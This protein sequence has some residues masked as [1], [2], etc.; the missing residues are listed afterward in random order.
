MPPLTPDLAS[1]AYLFI[2]A[3]LLG[4]LTVLLPHPESFN[5]QWML[6]VLIGSVAVGALLLAFGERVPEWLRRAAPYGAAA[7]TAIVLL[8][9]GRATSAYLFFYLWVALYAFCFLSWREAI[10]LALF[11]IASYAGVIAGFRI[12]HFEANAV[13]AN[14]DVPAMVLLAGTVFVAGAFVVLLRERVRSLISQLAT[15][16]GSDP[17]T[18]LL[19]RR[20]F[21]HAAQSE[22][23]RAERS[24]QRFSLLHTDCDFFKHLNDRLGHTAGDE[25]LVAIGWMLEADRR[26]Y[27]VVARIGGEEFAVLLPQTD[28]QE[29]YMVA[30]R[31]RTRISESFADQ[32]EPLTMSVGVATY[33]AHAT[34]LDG[35]LRAADDALYAAKALGRDRCVLHSPEIAGILSSDRDAINPRE[36]AQLA[37]VLNLAEALDM[38][39]TGTARH[40]QTVGRHCELMARELGLTREQVDRVRVA[41]VLHDIGKI[42][43]ADSILCKPGPLTDEEYEAMKKHPE[44]GARILG[45]SGLDDIRSWILA[46]HERPDGRGYPYGLTGKDIPLQAR[47]LAVGDAYEAMTSDRVYRRAIGAEAARQELR[48]NAGK[49]FDARVVDAL[50]KALSGR[51]D[52]KDSAANAVPAR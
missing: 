25:A 2:A 35:L 52:A 49:Q 45:G 32:A 19:S 13:Q 41:G 7:A 28:Q 33:P 29:A 10:A 46:H 34:T 14:E 1:K 38:R 47:I 6:A 31:L 50:F 21:H 51:G 18:G 5:E 40:S 48:D 36:Q 22:L 26:R 8:L 30:E 11:T 17:L 3:G 9:S 15:V 4:A 20:G 24:E 37:T 16:A 23:A 43:V 12:G 44:I 27:D 42:G 39:D